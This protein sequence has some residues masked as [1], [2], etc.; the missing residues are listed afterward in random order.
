MGILYSILY[1]APEKTEKRRVTFN[2]T[3]EICNPSNEKGGYTI[4][5]AKTKKGKPYKTTEDRDAGVREKDIKFVFMHLIHDW[6]GGGQDNSIVVDAI[7][8]ATETRER[9]TQ[10][11]IEQ[12]ST[13]ELLAQCTSLIDRLTHG[14]VTLKGRAGL[15]TV[16]N[17]TD[18]ERLKKAI[19]QTTGK[20]T[21]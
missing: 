19:Q 1:E 10:R 6:I 3:S 5:N 2:T 16:K 18:I 20:I 4:T 7:R 14:D 11:H 17:K 12:P 15:M 9:K 21:F 13:E 8:K